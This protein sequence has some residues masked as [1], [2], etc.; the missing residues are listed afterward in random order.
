MAR[1]YEYQGKEILRKSGI[2]V[3]KGRSASTPEEAARIAKEIG[4]PVVVKAQ[5]WAT[6]RFGAGGIKFADTPQR[7][8]EAAGMPRSPRLPRAVSRSFILPCP[9][10]DG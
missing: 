3:P 5:I 6:G 9:L 10:V 7:A 8:A 1:L 4:G 2:A